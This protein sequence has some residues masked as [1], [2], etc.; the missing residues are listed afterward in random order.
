MNE[1]ETTILN[2]LCDEITVGHVGP[3]ASEY[4]DEGVP[5]LRSQNVDPLCVNMTEIKYITPEFHARLRKSRLSPGDVVIVRTGKPGACSV[6]PPWLREANCSDLVIVRTGPR[7]NPRFLAY[8][9]NAVAHTHV[10][11]HLVGAVQQH[12]NVGSARKMAIRHP[13]IAVQNSIVNVLGSLDDKI[14]LNRRTSR[15]LEE[16]ARA[17]FKAWFIDFEPVKAKSA[18]ATSFPSLPQPVFE[19]LPHSFVNS[20]LGEIPEGWEVKPLGDVL[21]ITMGQSP[22]SVHYNESGEGLPFHQGVRDYGFRFP[23]HR[24]YCTLEA[25]L[26]EAGDV[27]LSVRAPVGRI[28]VAD[29]RLVIGRGLAAARHPNG[30]RSYALYLLKHLFA[31]EDAV[32][33]GTI[34]KAITKTF[35]F[36]M[37]VVC[38]PDGIIAEAER[39]LSSLDSLLGN[40]QRESRVLAE[41]RDLLLPKLISGEITV[42][43]ST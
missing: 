15:L 5:F 41:T 20:E 6:I 29:R 18:G 22:P 9:V 43:K 16:M 23:A 7:L 32:G 24:V 12:F 27:L 36:S 10:A 17:I 3:M 19:Q 11:A 25:R 2:E 34:Y 40:N 14:E 35:L 38:P 1:W 28:N 31:E 13:P 42:S 39:L 8:F 33:D 30:F 37:N 21:E 4:V 26:A